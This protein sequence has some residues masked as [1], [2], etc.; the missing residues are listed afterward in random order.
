MFAFACIKTRF[1]WSCM[2][3]LLPY[4][5]D[6]LGDAVA[7][8]ASGQQSVTRKK[9]EEKKSVLFCNWT[10]HSVCAVHKSSRRGGNEAGWRWTAGRRAA[11]RD[12]AERLDRTEPCSPQRTA[13]F[14]TCSRE[15]PTTWGAQR[16]TMRMIYI[17][18]GLNLGSFKWHRRSKVIRD[19]KNKLFLG[20]PFYIQL[21]LILYVQLSSNPITD[22]MDCMVETDPLQ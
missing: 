13:V 21:T 10:K 8:N 18:M 5:D 15:R 12:R 20:L 1:T 9:K 7:S 6:K 3:A 14:G 19:P 17:E 11:R 16:D 2:D 4:W 22:W